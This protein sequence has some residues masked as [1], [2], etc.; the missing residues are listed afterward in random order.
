[1]RDDPTLWLCRLEELVGSCSFI[2]GAGENC[3]QDEGDFREYRK[4]SASKTGGSIVQI[5][6]YGYLGACEH[7]VEDAMGGFT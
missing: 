4:N 7:N 5:G 3:H 6:R 2:H 1:M